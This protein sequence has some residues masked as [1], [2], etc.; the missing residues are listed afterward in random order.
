MCLL[1][2]GTEELPWLG[3]HQ[4]A[5]ASSAML[6]CANKHPLAQKQAAVLGFIWTPPQLTLCAWLSRQAVESSS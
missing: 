6:D 3:T 1:L 4:A 5:A 2:S